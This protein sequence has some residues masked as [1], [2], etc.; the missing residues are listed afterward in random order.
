MASVAKH[1]LPERLNAG[2]TLISHTDA[3]MQVVVTS[4]K[5]DYGEQ[6]YR[7]KFKSGVV[8]HRR[9][10]RD[11]LQAEGVRLRDASAH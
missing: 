1:D 3:E 11:E 9:W 10:T 2:D 6:L 8:G 4:R 7:L 5:S